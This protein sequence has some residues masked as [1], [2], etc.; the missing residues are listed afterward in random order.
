MTTGF[1]FVLGA[2]LSQ[3]CVTSVIVASDSDGAILQ[4]NPYSAYT[5]RILVIR[6]YNR[7]P[8]NSHQHECPYP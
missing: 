8:G 4:I 1:F 5:H 3:M 6:L 2:L 7:S